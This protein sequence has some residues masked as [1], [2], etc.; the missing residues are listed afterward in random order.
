MQL[1]TPAKAGFGRLV[2]CLCISVMLFIACGGPEQ[3]DIVGPGDDD[4][5]FLETYRD[6]DGDGLFHNVEDC[7]VCHHV[8]DINDNLALIADTLMTPNSG[9]RVV[10]FTSR[11]GANSFADGDE[12]YDGICEVCHTATNYHQNSEAGNHQHNAGTDCVLCHS[13]ALEFIATGGG[14]GQGHA[15][16]T[17][18]GIGLDL[19]CDYCHRSDL[20]AFQDGEPFATTHVCDECHSPGGILDGVDDPELGARSNWPEGVYDNGELATGKERWCAGCHDLG[21]SAVNGVSAPAVAG[22]GEWGFFST[23]HGRDGTVSCTNCHDASLPHFDGVAHSYRA[24][25]DNHSSAFR[26]AQL[27]GGA[28]L[29]VPRTGFDWDDPYSDP[30]YFD[31][32]FSCHDKYALLGGPSAPPGPYFTESMQTNFRQAASVII[33]DGE[34]TDIAAYSI[35]GAQAKNS[36]YTHLTG[37]PHFYDSDR[38]SAVDSYGTC[39]ACHNVHGSSSPANVRDGKLIGNEPSLNFSH[40][41]YDRHDPA[42]GGCGDPIVMT[43]ADVTGPQSHGGIMRANSGPAANGVCNFCHCGGGS[44]GDPEYVINCYDPD[45][46]DYYRGYIAPPPPVRR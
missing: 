35:M 32:C 15:T 40:V 13:H 44:T 7:E 31:L 20:S 12:V 11:Q 18:G 43:S 26:L 6:I 8:F 16:H 10:V 9:E 5:G 46:V 22:N 3:S 45:C 29:V 14:G 34:G 37:P 27:D 23:G 41:R 33:P 38:D 25:L 4:D 28:P 2:L 30:S 1:T 19:A 21:E 17:G 42:M 39:V 24:S 36:H